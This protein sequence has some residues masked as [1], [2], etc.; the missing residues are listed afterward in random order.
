MSETEYSPMVA[1]AGG[2]TGG[3]L[4]PALAVSEA[5]QALVPNLRCVFFGTNRPVDATILGQ[6][7]HELISQ[8]LPALRRAPW[9]WPDAALGY[10]REARRC[11]A[12]FATDRPI[13]VVGT[14]S[15]SSVPAVREAYR[16]GIPVGL[17]NPD[18]RPGRA[19]RHLAPMSR[20]IFAQWDETV[21][22]LPPSADVRV[23][24]CPVRSRFATA[25]RQRARTHFRLND[26]PYTLLVTGA[27]QGAHTVNEAV[28]AILG[29]LDT[30]D[31]WQVLHLSGE[32]DLECVRAAY[33]RY[34]IPARVIPFTHEMPQALAA[35][36]LVISRADASTLAELAVVGCPS[37][38]MP[39][40]FH[41][42]MHQLDNARCLE[43]AGA[44][45]IVVD[46]IDAS[47]NAP[48]LRKTLEP[49]LASEAL[50]SSMAQAARR[51]GHANAA[52]NVA[53]VVLDMAGA[54]ERA[55]T[56][57]MVMQ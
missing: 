55:A 10:W 16:A 20:V 30:L 19:N 11:R 13:A 17:L 7:S 21:R 40:P 42:D 18:A 36:D 46:G 49:L 51:A 57:E 6:T 15:I 3:H 31:E 52:Q 9:T 43:R 44:A 5:L 34:S 4:F 1:F 56:C 8:N 35:A 39:Y 22:H 27:S 23:L 32:A 26:R 28:V 29:F 54:T 2:G 33:N 14:G 37:V 12:R 24:G 38:L 47:R 48:L 45:R 53:D 41:K 25:D 50:R